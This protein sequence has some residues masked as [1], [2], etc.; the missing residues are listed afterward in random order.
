MA[1]QQQQ[2]GPHDHG[3]PQYFHDEPLD[4]D[5]VDVD[6]A[7]FMDYDGD[8]DM[9]GHAMALNN[10][11]TMTPSAGGVPG[12]TFQ[13]DG[14]DFAMSKEERRRE[15]RRR[16]NERTGKIV[17]ACLCVCLIIGMIVAIVLTREARHVYEVYVHPPHTDTP[18][19]APTSPPFDKP[20]FPT[21]EPTPK[22]P[23]LS[24]MTMPPHSAP[25]DTPTPVPTSSPTITMAP[26]YSVHDEYTFL[27]TI[28][29]YIYVD[30]PDVTQSF[31]VEDVFVVRHGSK[32]ETKPGE[33]VD[34]S[35][36]Y[37]FVQFGNLHHHTTSSSSSS[38]SSSSSSPLPS[39]DRW[40]TNSME[41]LLELSHIPMKDYLDDADI[42]GR[43]SIVLEVYFLPPSV[44]TKQ[45]G[46][47]QYKSLTGEAYNNAKL[48]TTGGGY[49][50]GSTTVQPNDTNISIDVT[51]AFMVV[52]DTTTSPPPFLYDDEDNVVTFLLKVQD[53]PKANPPQ[54]IGDRF[55]S[56]DMPKNDNDGKEDDPTKQRHGPYLH[57][58]N[59][60]Q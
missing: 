19:I 59:M 8:D 20:T 26:S 33:Q 3:G 58:S 21:L 55:V 54:R 37:S 15:R 2:H 17:A 46:G 12:T 44:D 11:M 27:A 50:V 38:G 34:I 32:Q 49:K 28:D 31:G 4:D 52:D 43:E 57:F 14:V 24:A 35:T 10:T 5:Y 23:S 53:G 7:N 30:G 6:G 18:T 25:T 22:P 1:R 9:T 47:L 48:G 13:F 36:A 41:V 45:H 51:K 39:K 56:R 42:Q 40:N 60:A 16:R 29:T